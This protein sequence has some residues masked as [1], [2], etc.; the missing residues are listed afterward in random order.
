ILFF[1]GLLLSLGLYVLTSAPP[2]VYNPGTI[3]FTGIFATLVGAFV[4][5]GIFSHN[6][7]ILDREKI[8]TIKTI[9]ASI[10][11]EL[12]TPLRT[13]T[14]SANFIKKFLP[15]L[16]IGYKRATENNLVEKS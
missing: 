12:R 2:F 7:D 9:G 1:T 14:S 5:G 10:A 13:I 16:V 11:H 6:K 8:Q 15:I 4:I 3:N